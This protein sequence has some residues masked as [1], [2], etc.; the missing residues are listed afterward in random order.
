MKVENGMATHCS[1]G[2]VVVGLKVGGIGMI[3]MHMVPSTAGFKKV[4]GISTLEIS[5]WTLVLVP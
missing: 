2:M 3:G 4:L 1:R 5:R